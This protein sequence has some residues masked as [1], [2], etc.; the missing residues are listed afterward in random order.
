VDGSQG[1]PYR[2]TYVREENFVERDVEMAEILWIGN[3]Q[4]AAGF[5]FLRPVA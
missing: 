3:G 5:I 2:H 1:L 4:Q